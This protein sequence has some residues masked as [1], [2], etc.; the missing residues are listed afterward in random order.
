MQTDTLFNNADQDNSPSATQ[1]AI[2]TTT[3]TEPP[4]TAPDKARHSA[5]KP[6]MSHTL[7]LDAVAARFEQAGVIRARR[8]FQRYCENGLLDC[9]KVD[10]PSGPQY[11]VDEHSVPRAIETTKALAALHT[12][13]DIPPD[14]ARHS[15]LQPAM[16]DQTKQET[17][18][19]PNPTP[20]TTQPAT[21]LTDARY[22]ARLEHDLDRAEL[23]IDTKNKQIDDLLERDK[24]TNFLVRGQQQI[25][26]RLLESPAIARL[27]GALPHPTGD[28][29]D[30]V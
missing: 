27:L 24:E 22:L 23:E 2:S 25:M 16:S 29:R 7:T 21:A 8:S 15:A 18:T 20:T 3:L 28:K 26:Q 19:P 1:P 30:E 11:Y 9:V 6:A 4:A 14:K 17:L 13:S 10:S 12:R 5:P